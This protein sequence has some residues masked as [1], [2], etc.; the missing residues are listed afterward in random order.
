MKPRQSNGLFITLEGGE[1]AGKTT[2]IDG[3]IRELTMEGFSVVSTR[4]PGGTP[5]GEEIRKLLLHFRGG[6]HPMTPK[7]ELMLF[8]AARAQ[9]YNEVILPSLQEGDIVICDRFHDSTIAYQGIA[10]GLGPEAVKLFSLYVTDGLEPDLTLYLDIDPNLAAKRGRRSEGSEGSR[11]N[12]DRIESEDVS[13]HQQVR[14]AFLEI[15]KS[16]PERC[17]VIDAT[18]TPEEVLKNALDSIHQ[19]DLVT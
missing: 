17:Q 4:E 16:A 8:L 12:K 6:E 9:H 10:R 14:S 13:F 5:V 7:T 2:L 3:L 18:K 11:Q 1:G 19:F 15:A